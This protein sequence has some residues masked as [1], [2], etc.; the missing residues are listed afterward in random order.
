MHKGSLTNGNFGSFFLVQ[1]PLILAIT[2]RA[3]PANSGPTRTTKE[4]QLCSNS[5]R[6]HISIELR[7]AGQISGSAGDKFL[8]QPCFLVSSVCY[9][10]DVY[11][12]LCFVAAAIGASLSN[13]LLA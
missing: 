4:G 1:W 9:I 7:L 2:K 8:L 11:T 13:G 12:P 5:G 10:G 3:F 6:S